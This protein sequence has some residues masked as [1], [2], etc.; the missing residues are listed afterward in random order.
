[1]KNTIEAVEN[2]QKKLKGLQSARQHELSKSKIYKKALDRIAEYH[3]R[4]YSKEVIEI[5]NII[6]DAYSEAANL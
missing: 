1:M 3:M 4:T 6:L 2:V 5:K